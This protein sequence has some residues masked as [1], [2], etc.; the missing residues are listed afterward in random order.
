MTR[1]REWFK[2]MNREI[3]A[4]M[5]IQKVTQKDLADHISIHAA[6][7]N[8]KLKDPFQFTAGEFGMVIDRLGIDCKKEMK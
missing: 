7:M 1:F 4:E 8:R 2:S 6:T 3:T 5:A